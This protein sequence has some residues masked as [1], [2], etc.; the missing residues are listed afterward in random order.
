MDTKKIELLNE[1]ELIIN[2]AIKEYSTQEQFDLILYD[3]VAFSSDRVNITDK[4]I[5]LI[6][7]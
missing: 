2:Q 1:I 7:K 3:N 4:I 5:E 6:E